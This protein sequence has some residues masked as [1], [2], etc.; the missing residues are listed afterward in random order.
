M[1]FLQPFNTFYLNSPVEH[2]LDVNDQ[3]LWR[4]E[5]C[6]NIF[7]IFHFAIR[8]CWH[9][10]CCTLVFPLIYF[11]KLASNKQDIKTLLPHRFKRIIALSE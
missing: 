10:F 11:I 6:L 4:F 3:I 9:Y 1:L 7:F 8:V 5:I 2:C